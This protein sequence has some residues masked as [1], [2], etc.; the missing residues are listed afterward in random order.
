MQWRPDTLL[1]SPFEQAALGDATVVRHRGRAGAEAAAAARGVVLHVHGYNDYFFQTHL[2]EAFAEA[3]YLFYAVDLRAAGRS[4]RPDQIPHYVADLREQAADIAR[5]AHAVRAAHPGLPLVVHAHSTGGLT[6]SLWAHSVRHATGAG[7]GPDALVLNSP[8]LELPGSAFAK[9][10]GTPLLDR[11][12]PLRPL[13][14]LSHHPSWYATALTRRWEFD[15]TLKRPE[16]LP[17]RA[18]WLRAVRR[19]QARV[20]RGLAIACP[21]LVAV[22]A[23]SSPDGPDN[24]L[25][26]STDTVLD[27]ELIAARAA[28]LGGRVTVERFEGGVHDLSLSDEGPRKAYV[29]SVLAWLATVLS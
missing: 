2:A 20:A 29:E 4:L 7:A 22:S 6:A 14:R 12:G 18:G 17:A 10:I 11:V 13:A 8:F 21:V 26:S 9:A 23:A 15:T 5:A 16:G 27:V 1:G 19:A 3:G 28:R 24:P 25:V